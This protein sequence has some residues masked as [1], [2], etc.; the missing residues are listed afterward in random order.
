MQ[1]VIIPH[2]WWRGI[3][4]VVV[5]V[6]LQFP[7]CWGVFDYIFST[8]NAHFSIAIWYDIS[9]GLVGY[10]LLVLFV[11]FLLVFVLPSVSC[12]DLTLYIQLLNFFSANFL[13]S[14]SLS[15]SLY[16]YTLHFSKCGYILC[17]ILVQHLFCCD[18]CGIASQKLLPSLH[19]YMC[20]NCIFCI[21]PTSIHIW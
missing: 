5:V 17:Y 16:I 11:I 19:P 13:F 21:D 8:F 18:K 6:V 15:L 9:G 4:V 14:L 10:I 2:G 7:F 20:G 1:C 12:L 3:V